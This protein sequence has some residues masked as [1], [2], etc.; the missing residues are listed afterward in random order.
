MK[1]SLIALSVL[2]LSS[3]IVYAV[4]GAGP[5]TSPAARAAATAAATAAANKAAAAALVAA[6]AQAALQY[7][8]AVTVIGNTLGV[9]NKFNSPTRNDVLF[10]GTVAPTA[11]VVEATCKQYSFKLAGSVT[12]ASV[13]QGDILVNYPCLTWIPTM[14]T[15][16]PGK[17][18]VEIAKFCSQVPATATQLFEYQCN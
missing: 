15:V 16:Q 17:F 6:Q 1:K 2:M 18:A 14:V 4:P 11:A 10:A 13:Q 3:T 5:A 8:T 9:K 7:P 12:A